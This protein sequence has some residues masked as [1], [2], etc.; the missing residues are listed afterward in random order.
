VQKGNIIQDEDFSGFFNE[1]PLLP[2]MMI[3]Y[4]NVDEN[5]VT[6]SKGNMTNFMMKP[7]MNNIQLSKSKEDNLDSQQEDLEYNPIKNKQLVSSNSLMHSYFVNKP[8]SN[9]NL[10]T[11]VNNDNQITL[12]SNRPISSLNPS[13][14]NPNLILFPF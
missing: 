10:N 1:K 12:N 4:D 2:K 6:K 3:T 14:Q 13:F 11:L 8:P 5:K 9:T 7:N